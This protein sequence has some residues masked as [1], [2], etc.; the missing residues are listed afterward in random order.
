MATAERIALVTG[1]NKGIGYEIAAGLGKLGFIVGV[2][3]R[4]AGRRAD[5]V[6]R[7]RTSGCDVFD[8]ALDVT[9]DASVSSAAADVRSRYDH[10]DVLVNNAGITGGWNQEPTKVAAETV[11]AA[12]ETNVIGTIRVTNAFLPL[13][14]ASSAPRIV[15][16]SSGGASL[17]W[18]TGPDAD[19]WLSAAY[20]PSKTMLNA[21][22]IQY[23]KELAPTPVKINVVDPGY[24]ATD[25]TNFYG[26]RTPAEAAR[27]AIELA[28]I[29]DDGPTGAFFSE[30][31]PTPW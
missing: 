26:D 11:R 14:M 18:Q 24:T 7:L 22:T 23:A 30:A 27:V 5:A 21:V 28:T 12:V 1:A 13:L 6:S 20:A 31:G 3:A 4:D 9:D 25:L 10:L 16:V 2:A 29:P 8:I 15:N 17:S 19:A